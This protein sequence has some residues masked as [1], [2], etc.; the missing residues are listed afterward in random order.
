MSVGPFTA[1]PGRIRC[2]ARI[3]HGEVAGVKGADVR[4][5]CGEEKLKFELW[6]YLFAG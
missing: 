6:V 4:V 5:L 3:R 1:I 2:G